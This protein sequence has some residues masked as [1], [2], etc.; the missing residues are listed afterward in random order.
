MSTHDPLR[1]AVIGY[2][3]GGE[4]FH[5]PLIAA[6]PGLALTTVI[7]SNEQ[8]AAAARSRYPEVRVLPSADDLWGAAA[9]HD[10][11]VITTANSAHVPLGLAALRA[12]LP[13]VIDKPVAATTEAAR[14]LRDL[15]AERNLLISVYHNRRWDGDF[16]TLR[17]MLADGS[18]GQVHR[19]ESRFERWRPQLNGETWRENPEPDQA[20]GLLYDLG[21]HLIDQALVAFGP[22]S[23]VFAEVRTLRPGAK[24]DDDVFLALTHTGGT[25]SHLWASAV[26]ADLGPRLRVL[27][28]AG[29]YVKDGLDVQEDA[30]R[31]GGSPAAPQWGVEPPDR[32]GV[33]GTPGDS[34]PLETLPGAYQDYYALVRDAVRDATA[35]PVTIEDAIEV[36]AIIEDAQRSAREGVTVT[37]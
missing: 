12:G 14:S 27:G 2:G 36:I 25:V 21:S 16:L 32:W 31:S 19:F 35:P 9:E 7:T 13:V 8:R 30:L 18:L 5:A 3:L 34:S 24:V 33:L 6:T 29:S 26:A 23:S 10:L 15:A 11:V 4:A 37:R 28:S 22:V 1:T 17:R 20:G